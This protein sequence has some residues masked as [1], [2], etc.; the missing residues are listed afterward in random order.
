[1][2]PRPLARPVSSMTP[3]IVLEDGMPSMVVGGSGGMRIASSVTLVVLSHFL[4]GTSPGDAV[5]WPRVNP[6]FDG[7]L[8][9]E[10]DLP[11]NVRNDL[12][13]LGETIS[14]TPVNI[15]AVQMITVERKKGFARITSASDL[16]KDGVPMTD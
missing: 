11:L 12:T 5:G 4:F 1:N 9:V 6:L 14:V 10:P 7:T 16:R 3:T 2:A 8:Q 13:K 15:N